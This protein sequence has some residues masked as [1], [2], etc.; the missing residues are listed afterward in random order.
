LE[1]TAFRRGFLLTPTSLVPAFVHPTQ[2]V[3]G[4]NALILCARIRSAL[5]GIQAD[6]KVRKLNETELQQAH[7]VPLAGVAIEPQAQPSGLVPGSKPAGSETDRTSA[8]SASPR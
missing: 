1:V 7:L 8:T 3:V 5:F 2:P 4:G 6:R